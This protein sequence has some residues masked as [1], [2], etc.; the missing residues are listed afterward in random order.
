M[1]FAGV[2]IFL[3]KLNSAAKA[4]AIVG[5]DC[6]ALWNFGFANECAGSVSLPCLA[7]PVEMALES[8]TFHRRQPNGNTETTDRLL[9]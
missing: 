9:E 3:R 6:R 2:Y 7:S 8:D 1:G 4:E 5:A